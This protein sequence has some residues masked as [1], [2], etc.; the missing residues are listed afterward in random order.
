M[1]GSRLA[2]SRVPNSVMQLLAKRP[3]FLLAT[4]LAVVLAGCGPSEPG[5]TPSPSS[6]ATTGAQAPTTSTSTSESPSPSASDE[7]PVLVYLIRGGMLGVSG[8][9]VSAPGGA[10]LR[11]ALDALLSGPSTADRS[12]GLTTEIPASADLLGVA[13]TGVTATVDLSSAF[14]RPAGHLAVQR[15][16]A[17]IVA[18]A[19]Q[20]TNVRRVAFAIEGSPV[21]MVGG[22][23]ATTPF[24]TRQDIERVSP[25]VLV[26]TVWPGAQFT[27]PV[28]FAGTANTFE[29]VVPWRVERSD[30]S[31]VAKGSTMATS[32]TGTR[33]TFDLALRLGRFTGGAV[34]V[35]GSENNLTGGPNFVRQIEIPFTV[36]AGS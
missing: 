33:G 24:V 6:D 22:G 31:I 7:T 32:G 21:S 15:R 19:T 3:L 2:T 9:Q 14:D 35:T 28:R 30:G 11:A 27:S 1:S 4:S 34:L 36:Q 8:R 17:Q 20:F 18:T 16:V 13:L 25:Q 5:A 12:G 10:V 29:A 23:F 26:E